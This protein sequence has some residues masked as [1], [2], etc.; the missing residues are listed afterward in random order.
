MIK[1]FFNKCLDDT[2]L[3]NSAYDNARDKYNAIGEYLEEYFLD[4]Y[5]IDVKIYSQGSFATETVVR[6]YTEGKDRSYDVDTIIELNATKQEYSSSELKRIIRE[7]LEDSRYRDDFEEWDKCFTINYA[8][9]G[10]YKFS[11]DVVPSISEDFTTKQQL[12]KITEE[13]ERVDTSIA[14]TASLS[15]TKDDEWVTNNPKGYAEWFNYVYRSVILR[16]YELRSGVIY[17]SIE[18]LPDG[19]DVNQVKNIVKALKRMMAVFYDHQGYINK[20]PSI[21]ISTIVAKL[22]QNQFSLD[23]FE[24]LKY[25]IENIGLF[26]NYRKEMSSR[27]RTEEI[28]NIIRK[29]DGQ[30]VME[31]PCNGN[32]NLIDS[33]NSDSSAPENFIE[34]IKYLQNTILPSLNGQETKENYEIIKKAFASST[35]ITKF[36]VPKVELTPKAHIKPWRG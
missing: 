15:T 9:M 13:S 8:S 21:I 7:A 4:N 27:H 12:A 10:S 31:N 33:W 20:P 14:I 17:S 11:I 28:S 22:S 36:Y 3:S 29:E 30:W 35:D 34:F 2:T 32:D 24:H 25:I 23:E 19:S 18:E 16:K 5:N 26:S 1:E 6:P